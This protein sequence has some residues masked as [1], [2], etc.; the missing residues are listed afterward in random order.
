MSTAP[1]DA[2]RAALDAI[3]GSTAGITPAD[4]ARPTPCAD[5]DLAALLGHVLGAMRYYARLARDG[6]A[7]ARP[8][9]L[10]IGPDDDV[11]AMLRAEAT[12]AV[13]AWSAPGAL[14]RMVTMRL[15]PMQGADA[16]AI[17]VADLAVHAW[18]IAAARGRPLELP[19]ELAGAALGTWRRVLAE[20]DLRPIAF[21]DTTSVPPD[22]SPTARLLAFCGRTP[23]RPL[24]ARLRRRA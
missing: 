11:F 18:D 1:I 15:G 13:A 14:E 2:Y 12:N 3:R 21:A 5:W 23:Q 4:L 19:A 9:T 24:R 6:E 22:A 16:L 7:P 8:V 17:H 20:H 10:P